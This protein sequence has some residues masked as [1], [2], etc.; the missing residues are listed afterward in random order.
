MAW[1]QGRAGFSWLSHCFGAPCFGASP[2]SP[3]G[4]GS[5]W[6]GRA[7]WLQVCF[8]AGAA[9]AVGGELPRFAEI[10]VAHL[11]LVL[12]F[13]FLYKKGWLLAASTLKL[14]IWAEET[15]EESFADLAVAEPGVTANHP[16]SRFPGFSLLA[17]FPGHS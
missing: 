1:L 5:F 7:A 8:T 6:G 2:V 11:K 10:T 17:P 3:P 9:G 12:L 13:E 4:R 14:E 16:D 15:A